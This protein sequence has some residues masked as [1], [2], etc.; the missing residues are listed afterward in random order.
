MVQSVY[1]VSSGNTGLKGMYGI[2][3]KSLLFLQ[4]MT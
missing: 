1:E 4:K 2:I 3:I